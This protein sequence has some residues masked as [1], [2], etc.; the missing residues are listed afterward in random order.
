MERVV[1]R[2]WSCTIPKVMVWAPEVPPGPHPLVDMDN[3]LTCHVYTHMHVHTHTHT[4]IYAC[5]LVA[6]YVM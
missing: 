2:R 4:H 1:P 5:V 3:S 6:D